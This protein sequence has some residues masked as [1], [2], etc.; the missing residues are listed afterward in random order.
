MRLIWLCLCLVMTAPAS[1]GDDNFGGLPPGPG[2]DEVFAICDACHSIKLVTQQG[3]S[4]EVWNDIL[5]YMIEEQGMAA[6]DPTERALILE[7]LAKNFGA[8]LKQP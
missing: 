8:D 5:D 3:L 4:R 7:Y 2:R 1:A 6:L